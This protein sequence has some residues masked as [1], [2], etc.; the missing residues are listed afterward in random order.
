MATMRCGPNLWQWRIRRER[1]KVKADALW[2][3]TAPG[4]IRIAYE[5][6]GDDWLEAAKDPAARFRPIYDVSQN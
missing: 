5:V 6:I 3:G 2:G 4:V 1:A